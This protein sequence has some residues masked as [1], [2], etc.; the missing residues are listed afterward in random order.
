MSLQPTTGLKLP[1]SEILKVPKNLCKTVSSSLT[2]QACSLDFLASTK[3]SMKNVSCKWS[4]IAG[5]MLKMESFYQGKKLLS[6]MLTLMKKT[7]NAFFKGCYKKLLFWKI[8]EDSQK[9]VFT[10]IPRLSQRDVWLSRDLI[11]YKYFHQ[12]K[13]IK[14]VFAQ[15]HSIYFKFW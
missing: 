6:R 7:L 8:A 1:C 14:L 9:N 2:L 11:D 15:N 10:V 5:N 12:Q 4:E 13:L 3:H